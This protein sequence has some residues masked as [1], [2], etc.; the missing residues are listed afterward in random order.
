M[1]E[2]SC[3]RQFFALTRLDRLRCLP[4]ASTIEL[5][6]C[7]HAAELPAAWEDLTRSAGLFLQR[8]VLQAV[9]QEV[10]DEVTQ[11]Y[12]LL[13]FQGEPFAALRTQQ[14]IA[15]DE[16]L[17]VRER[18]EHNLR[19]RRLGRLLEQATTW[20][21][22][23]TLGLLGRRVLVCGN[24]YSCGM[25]GVA[26]EGGCDSTAA[27]PDVIAGLD[28]LIEK[29]GGAD[30]VVIKDFPAASTTH[31]EAL[32]QAGFVSLRVEPC[33][34]LRLKPAWRSRED[35]L[36]ALNTKYR[37][38]ARA[39]DTAIEQAGISVE[40]MTDLRTEAG[41]IHELYAQVEKRAQMRFGVVRPGYFSAL[42]AAAGT[43]NWR[44][45]ALRRDGVLLGFSFVLRDGATAHA[46][47]V[48]FDYEAN[49][50]A[51]LYLR[52]LHSVIDDALAL[53][54]E[55]AHFGRTAL[56]PKA[57]L[58]ATPQPTEIWI[59]HRVALLNP[60]IRLLLRLVPQDDAPV[61]DPFRR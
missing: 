19:Q 27:W 5:R 49:R 12:A 55:E 54:C 52:L 38:A 39:T 23:R 56:E 32:R 22:N 31:R 43:G 17:A 3:A 42:A 51:P 4:A 53:G 13:H 1:S 15:G 60:L 29:S 46:H 24:L 28:G 37:K 21:R 20:T 14:I 59:R 33:M 58:G 9:E 44:C 30:F 57:R 35:Y 36:S 48:G 26:I 45:T 18:T 41:R 2:Y 6:A 10:P 8:A 34:V 40:T 25:D 16:L 7:D 47:V 11:R 50:E 61:R